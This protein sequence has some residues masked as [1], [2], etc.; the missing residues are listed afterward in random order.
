MR[1]KGIVAVLIVT[2]VFAAVSQAAQQRNWG[3][4][5]SD[6]GRFLVHTDGTPFFYLGDTAWELFH[7]LTLQE[8]AV[9]LDDRAKNGYTVIQAVVLAELDGLNV[10]NAE[11][12]KPL[13]NNDPEKINEAYFRHVDKVVEMARER[14][15]YVAMLPTWGDKVVKAPWSEAGQ[16]IFTPEKARAYGRIVGR[17][18]R[19][20]PNIIWVLGGDRDPSGVETVWREMAAGIKEGDGGRHLMTFHPVGGHSSADKFHADT[21]LDFNMRQ[22]GHAPQSQ[23]RSWEKITAD[24]ARVPVKPVIDAEPLYEDHPLAF[25]AKELGYSFDAHVRQYAYADIFAGACGFT[26]GNHAVWQMYGPNRTPVNGPL[27]YWYEAIHRPGATQMRFVRALLES[28]PYLSRVPD[29][30][31]V[32]DPLDGADHVS[33]T[34]GD[35]YLFVYS[36]QGRKFTVRAGKLSA[37]RLKGWWFNPRTGNAQC[38]GE[39]ENAEKEFVPPSEGFG[40]D[41]VLVLDDASRSFPAPGTLRE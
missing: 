12:E 29:Q 39:L 27:M 24:Y 28:R 20:Q 21:W 18:Y 30:S 38:I 25:N 36:A 37:N 13:L 1:G 4:K 34:R 40:S 16:L 15:L 41:W 11:G 26:Y 3:L 17:R 32:V 5:V 22:N 8:S 10:P 6:N 19:N 14:G 9:Y 31:I 33:A 23:S 2:A 7:R 35:G